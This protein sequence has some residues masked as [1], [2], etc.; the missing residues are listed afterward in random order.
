MCKPGSVGD[1]GGQPPRS[2]RPEDPN[3]SDPEDAEEK[4]L[5][6]S[7]PEDRQSVWTPRTPPDPEDPP[8]DPPRTPEIGLT[9]GPPRRW[10][11]TS[12]SPQ[13]A[14]MPRSVWHARP[15]AHSFTTKRQRPASIMPAGNRVACCLSPSTCSTSARATWPRAASSLMV[16]PRARPKPTKSRSATTPSSAPSKPRKSNRIGGNGSPARHSG[17]CSW[18]GTSTTGESISECLSNAGNDPP[19]TQPTGLLVGWVKGVL[20]ATHRTSRRT[21]ASHSGG[22]GFASLH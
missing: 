1:L 4:I 21:F 20:A 3:R 9:P 8:E 11:R 22:S 19:V 5:N 7:D 14:V 6:R 12:W 2:T 10:E 16:C 15:R 18:S 13:R 17:Y